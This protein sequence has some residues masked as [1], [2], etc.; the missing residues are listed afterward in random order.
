MVLSIVRKGWVDLKNYFKG[1]L[2]GSITVIIIVSCVVFAKNIQATF[3]DVRINING[4]DTAQWGESYVL[5]DGREVPY[6]IIYN[7]TTYL[8]LRKIGELLDKKVYWNGDTKTVSITGKPS[9]MREITKKP[10]KYG[11]IWTYYSFVVDTQ[12]YLSVKDE[13]RGYE[14]IY[15]TFNDIAIIDDALYFVKKFEASWG[16]DA[17]LCRLEFDNDVNNQDG[18]TIYLFSNDTPRLLSVAFDGEYVYYSYDPETNSSHGR[19]T[20]MNVKDIQDTVRFV[21][22]NYIYNV[23][24]S[25]DNAGSTI[26]YYATAM[27]GGGSSLGEYR[28]KFNDEK[29]CFEE[30]ELIREL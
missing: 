13:T 15:K 18:E 4:S 27:R 22:G 28:M 26:V 2:S 9:D 1:F 23:R 12:N 20:R 8:P 10:D 16:Y 3:N 19:I 7:D 29:N 6:S 5:D 30:P 21:S 17:C 11:N 25:K 24:V 14:R